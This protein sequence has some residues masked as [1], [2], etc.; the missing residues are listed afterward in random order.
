[1]DYATKEKAAKAIEA[2]G[3]EFV[4]PAVMGAAP[5]RKGASYAWVSEFWSPRHRQNRYRAIIARH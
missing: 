5:W 1:M 2:E 3:F 4:K